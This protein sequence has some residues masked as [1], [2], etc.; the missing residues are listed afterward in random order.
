MPTFYDPRYQTWNGWASLICE[1]YADQSLDQPGDEANWALWADAVKG[2]DTFAKNGIPAP[3][4]YDNW[5]DWAAQFSSIMS[6]S[7]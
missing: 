7:D 6:V 5:Q 3:E 2:I 1:E 4:L